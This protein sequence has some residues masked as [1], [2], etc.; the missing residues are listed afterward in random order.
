MT[1]VNFILANSRCISRNLPLCRGI[2]TQ[3]IIHGNDAYNHKKYSVTQHNLP[4]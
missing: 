2:S 3:N 4:D 1:T